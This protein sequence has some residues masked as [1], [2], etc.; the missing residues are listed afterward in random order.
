MDDIVVLAPRTEF[1]GVPTLRWA[2]DSLSFDIATLELLAA[3]TQ[4]SKLAKPRSA[5]RK[6]FAN[7]RKFFS[8]KT[9][10]L[11]VSMKSPPSAMVK[12]RFSAS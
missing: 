7:A 2:M 10:S 1:M 3:L 8:L 4:H 6:S 11:R 5:S 12:L 9:E